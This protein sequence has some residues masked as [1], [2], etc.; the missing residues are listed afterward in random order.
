M[1]W[2]GCMHKCFYYFM[3][4]YDVYYRKYTNCLKVSLFSYLKM[5]ELSQNSKHRN[6]ERNPC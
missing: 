6:F 2:E 3:Y 1:T 4:F 5:I